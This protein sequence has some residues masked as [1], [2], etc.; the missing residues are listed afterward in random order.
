MTTNATFRLNG[1]EPDNLLGFLA[2]LGLL[3]ALEASRPIWY[4][5]A[6]WTVDAPPIRPSLCIPVQEIG[7]SQEDR[8]DEKEGEVVSIL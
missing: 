5:R 6:S 4:P 1:I 7:R 8:E 2:L 3:R